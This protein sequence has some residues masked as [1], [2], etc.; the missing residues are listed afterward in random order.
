MPRK[1]NPQDASVSKVKQADDT[2][3][4]RLREE[5]ATLRELRR[6]IAKL[7]KR[8]D[9]LERKADVLGAFV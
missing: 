8:V 5:R 6:M 1:R 2:L 3:R 7:T 9:E 4:K